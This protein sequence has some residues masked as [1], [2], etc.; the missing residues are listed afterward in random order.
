[1]KPAKDI[2]ET[3]K[4]LKPIIG[5][6]ADKLWHM[7]LAED[8]RGR[9]ELT[10]DIDIVAEK[11]LKKDPLVKNEI[12]LSPPSVN[13]SLGSFLIGDVIY[14]RKKLHPL[15]LKPEDFTKQVGIFA[16][17]GEGK[18]NLAYLLAL[19]LLKSK[20][21]FIAID[22]K[23]SWRS[24]LSLKDRF[25][26]LEQVQVFTIG[27]DALPF[28]WNP[29][30]APPG[31]NTDSWISAIAEALE[32]SHLSG[33]GVAYHIIR[34]YQK[35][36]TQLPGDFYP[37]FFD[38]LRDI[39]NVKA[40]ERELRWKQTASRI[41]QTFTTGPASK[42]F[43]ARDPI[44]LEDL[45]DKPVIL[46][47]DLEM[48][49]PLRTFFSEIILRWIHLYRVSQGE[50]EK[51]RHVLFLEEA[52]NLFGQT[53]MYKESDSLENVYREIR[54]FGQGLVSITQHPSVLPVYLLGNC[55]TQIYLGLQHANDI[56]TARQSLFLNRDEEPYPSMLRVGECITK[57]KN[58][59]DPCL[60]KIPLVPV[61]KGAI[62]DNWLQANTPGYLRDPRDADQHPHPG[63]L[64]GAEY[65]E[66]KNGKDPNNEPS[67]HD[68]L[69]LD[70]FDNPFSAITQR[71]KRLGLNPKYG[72][73]YKNLLISRGCIQPKKIVTTKGWITLFDLT[74][75]G[76]AVLRDLGHGIK[77]TS[78]GIVH[79]YWKYKIAQ[80]YREQNLKVQVEPYVNGKPDIVVMN[81]DKRTAVEIETGKSDVVHNVKKAL[82]AGF[83]EVICVAT[84]RYA[85]DKIRR[86]L[87]NANMTDGNVKITSV[88][89][90]DISNPF[91]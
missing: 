35:L 91:Q 62:T 75:K 6:E 74:N 61:E 73:K 83:D 56:R 3:C 86:L 81:D 42:A 9:R 79:R 18:T 84:S 52:H 69:L 21:P 51:L 33:P 23:R 59:I 68:R 16:V 32:K 48:P 55:H 5:E 60:V 31:T 77:N 58:R 65:I 14:N 7:Y 8:E 30:R 85:D 17:T 2:E 24:L 80:Y 63:Y 76:K 28:L 1:M 89:A 41:F 72:N 37:N 34:I 64:P 26:E 10:L 20:I 15:Y 27:R 78:E 90:F 46:E 11:L 50:T 12:L 22:W 25:P 47:L 43:N 38:G 36:F 19:Q 53:G 66:G 29:F 88:L 54:S 67:P 70:I 82:N 49:K 40:Y 71:Y 4:K 44:K 87:E 45:L 39:K 57:I 13:D